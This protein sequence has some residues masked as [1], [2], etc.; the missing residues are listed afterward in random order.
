MIILSF[1]RRDAEALKVK[2]MQMMDE[3]NGS[4]SDDDDVMD[5]SQKN[6]I[7]GQLWCGTIHSFAINILR[8]FN[9]CNDAPLRI[10]SNKVMKNRIRSCLGKIN[11]S[12]KDRLMMYKSALE[13]SKQSIGTLVHYIARCLELWKEAGLLSTPYSY[14]INFQGVDNRVDDDNSLNPDD[15]VELAMRLGIPQNAA[16]LALDISGDY[17]VRAPLLSC[18]HVTPFIHETYLSFSCLD[19]S[20]WIGDG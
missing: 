14:T 5:I 19:Y 12:G 1:T 2:A 13:D 6:T 16:L 10:I 11:G 7:E 8:K 3:G 4:D 17:Q 18:Q 20:C 15:Y 9:N